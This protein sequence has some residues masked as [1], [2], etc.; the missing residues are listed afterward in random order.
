VTFGLLSE[1]ETEILA[2]TCLL[3]RI[4]ICLKP[5]LDDL[6]HRKLQITNRS[7][8]RPFNRLIFSFKCQN[9][10]ILSPLATF[11]VTNDDRLSLIALHLLTPTAHLFAIVA[12]GN[13]CDLYSSFVANF[14]FKIADE[15][16]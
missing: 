10:L 6:T 15:H 12:I 5:R 11:V 16:Q 3:I 2:I 8:D 7:R 4:S 9:N 1:T 14:D 13:F